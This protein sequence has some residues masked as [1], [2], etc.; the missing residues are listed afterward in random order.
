MV[1]FDVIYRMLK[2]VAPWVFGVVVVFCIC[3][4]VLFR[5]VFVLVD[6]LWVNVVFSVLV[7]VAVT[8]VI[9]FVLCSILIG[10]TDWYDDVKGRIDSEKKVVGAVV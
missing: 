10:L 6:D 4:T 8:P 3:F 1:R 9:I 7:S 5:Y 2:D